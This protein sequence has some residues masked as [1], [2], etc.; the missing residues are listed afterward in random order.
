MRLVSNTKCYV[1]MFRA[2]S[3]LPDYPRLQ[4]TFAAHLFTTRP[5]DFGMLPIQ[6]GIYV[7]MLLSKKDPLENDAINTTKYAKRLH[8]LAYPSTTTISAAGNLPVSSSLTSNNLDLLLLVPCS[9]H[10]QFLM[11]TFE[12]THFCS[13]SNLNRMVSPMDPDMQ[14]S[15]S[16]SACEYTC[17]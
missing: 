1:L 4:P 3:P 2:T 7:G 12:E 13:S 15:R 14:S 10:S 11:K 8:R 5:R 9:F 6:R 17:E 16:P